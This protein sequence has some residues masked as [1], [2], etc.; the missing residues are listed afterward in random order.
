MEQQMREGE[1]EVEAIS[2]LL[3]VYNLREAEDSKVATDMDVKKDGLDKDF[4]G[5]MKRKGEISETFWRLDQEDLLIISI[6]IQG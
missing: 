1:E 4:M 6:G 3:S 2:N 5:R